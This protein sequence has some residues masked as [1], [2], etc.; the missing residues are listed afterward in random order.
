ML[1]SPDRFPALELWEKSIAKPSNKTLFDFWT[2]DRAVGVR[3]HFRQMRQFMLTFLDVAE[4]IFELFDP[5]EGDNR[6]RAETHE[7]RHVPS[8][9]GHRTLAEGEADHVKRA[10]GG[11][12][13]TVAEPRNYLGEYSTTFELSR[14]GVHGARFAHVQRHRERGCH[15]SLQKKGQK[16][17]SGLRNE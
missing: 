6:V 1:L 17:R 4:S 14:L 3:G 11:G 5:D 7:G 2:N 13:L 16:R 8:E 9:K 10:C 12:R 15:S